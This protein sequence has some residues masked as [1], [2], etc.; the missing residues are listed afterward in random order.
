M[1]RVIMIDHDH[2]I[3]LN[4]EEYE[5]MCAY[6]EYGYLD[7]IFDQERESDDH[8]KERY[9]EALV[10]VLN[11]VTWIAAWHRENARYL[12]GDELQEKQNKLKDRAFR[13]LMGIPSLLGDDFMAELSKII[14]Q[15]IESIFDFY[16]PESQW[17][18]YIV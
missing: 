10:K 1:R 8:S 18:E 4:E 14:T 9:R 15:R 2:E 6:M 3:V 11:E 12:E 13:R 16:G 7:S 17:T 5:R